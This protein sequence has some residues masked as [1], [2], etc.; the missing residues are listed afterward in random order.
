MTTLR[1][2]DVLGVCA[3]AVG[4]NAEDVVADL[5]APD[6]RSGCLDLPGQFGTEDALPRPS[7][8]R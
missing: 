6:G 7:R 3:E 4:V 5:E 1:D 2:A 8:G